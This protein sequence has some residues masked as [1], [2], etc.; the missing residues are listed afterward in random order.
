MILSETTLRE[1]LS[2]WRFFAEMTCK[3]VHGGPKWTE[4]CPQHKEIIRRADEVFIAVRDAARADTDAVLDMIRQALRLGGCLH[5]HDDDHPQTPP[6]LYPEWIACAVAQARAD[7][8]VVCQRHGCMWEAPEAHATCRAEQ[9]EASAG[10]IY[11]LA[12]SM[13]ERGL[14]VRDDFGEP[15]IHAVNELKAAIRA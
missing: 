10:L 8:A 5:G 3:A 14:F 9:R 13:A 7:L 4:A 12:H 2:Q 11:G 6:M 1:R 15:D